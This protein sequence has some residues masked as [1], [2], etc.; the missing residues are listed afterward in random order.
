MRT[1]CRTTDYGT[2]WHYQRVPKTIDFGDFANH[3][4]LWKYVELCSAIK[5]KHFPEKKQAVTMW[6]YQKWTNTCDFADFAKKRLWHYVA[7]CGT[8]WHYQK[9]PKT[10]ILL[11]LPETGCG[12][13]RHYVA[14]CGTIKIKHFC[15]KR[16]WHYVALCGT[17]K[18]GQKQ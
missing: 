10:M 17:I 8:M 12:T 3:N 6:H 18:N 7:L 14:L 13:M 2:M 1:L 9:W 4:M 5:I 15:K 11:I 16:P